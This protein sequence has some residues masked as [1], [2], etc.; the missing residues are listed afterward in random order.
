MGRGR[1]ATRA[2]R[3]FRG[4][5]RG[6]RFKTSSTRYYIHEGRDGLSFGK[7]G[8]KRGFLEITRAQRPRPRSGPNFRLYSCGT[9]AVRGTVYRVSR[10]LRGVLPK[11]SCF[12]PTLTTFFPSPSPNPSLAHTESFTR[13]L[14]FSPEKQT[15]HPTHPAVPTE[16]SVFYYIAY[17]VLRGRCDYLLSVICF[18][19]HV[20]ARTNDLILRE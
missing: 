6:R 19:R 20:R 8:T 5:Y 17:S 4:G 15:L 7:V 9:C 14:A 11:S 1:R 3:A 12:S 16:R 18:Y 13:S 2:R 10:A